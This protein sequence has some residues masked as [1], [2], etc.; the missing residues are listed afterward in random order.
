[1]TEAGPNSLH[2]ARAVAHLERSEASV[3][4]GLRCAAAVGL[5][6]AVGIAIG[7]PDQGGWGA[8][9]AFL[10][11]MAMSQPGH[12]FRARVVAGAGT[13]VALGGLLGALVGIGHW[14]IFPLA[15]L[16]AITAGLLVAVGPTASLVAVSAV[17]ALLYG[18]SL[19]ASV[20]HALRVGAWMLAAGLAAAAIGRLVAVIPVINRGDRRLA[21]PTKTG[22][23]WL[24][25]ARAAFAAGAFRHS[26]AR[27]HASRLAVATCFATWLYRVLNQTD[28]FW[29][30]ESTLFIGR[31]DAELTRLRSA[32]RVVGTVGGVTLTTLVL[33]VLRPG[34]T[35]LAVL[36][37]AASALAFSVQRVNFALYIVFVTVIFVLLTAFEGVPARDAVLDRLVF[38]L[39]GA[40]IAVA[41]LWLWPG[42]LRTA[43]R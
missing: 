23:A 22:R 25:D 30:P 4:T 12:R 6:L 27:H 21:A 33:V 13:A 43:P 32:Q 10:T 17:I 42:G 20:A 35:G 16:G 15:A 31:P 36:A 34:S 5:P 1:M 41:S 24:A 2:W 39:M 3:H 26:L 19:H 18:A 37:V 11:D 38:N 29:I 40:A 14:A 9:G 28:G 7:Q 8:V